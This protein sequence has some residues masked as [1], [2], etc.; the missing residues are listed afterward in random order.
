METG[1]INFSERKILVIG[2]IMLDVYRKGSADRISPEAPVPVVRLSSSYSVPGGAANVANNIVSLGASATLM[3]IVGM[4]AAG[5]ELAQHLSRRGILKI[6]STGDA[7]TITKERIIGN[8]DQQMLRIDTEQMIGEFDPDHIEKLPK[9]VARHDL[10]VVSDYAKGTVKKG[11]MDAVVSAALQYDRKII[12]D[13]KPAN[14]DIYRGA[15]LVTPN[16]KEAEEMSGMPDGDCMG[17]AYKLHSKIG[18][19]VLITRGEHGMLGY[20]GKDTFK[21]PAKAREVYDVSGA[22]DTVTAVMALGIASGY[23]IRESAELANHAAG[24]VVGKR[25]T[26]TVTLDEL[27]KSVGSE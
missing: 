10:V 1:K 23:S 27:V 14:A 26:A 7:P 3:G 22:G 20:D 21:L 2:D 19:N 8:N 4:D 9:I 16:Q 5:G 24:V 17:I 15:Y 11:L 25:G 12:V 6:L 13:P 18:S